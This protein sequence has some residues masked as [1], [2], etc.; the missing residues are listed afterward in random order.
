MLRHK[1]TD[2]RQDNVENDDLLRKIPGKKHESGAERQQNAGLGKDHEQKQAGCILEPRTKR[3][4]IE[5][6][7]KQRR[8]DVHRPKMY[9]GIPVI[10]MKDPFCRDRDQRKGCQKQEI[11]DNDQVVCPGDRFEDPFI[12]I[13]EI[14]HDEET[15]Q[16]D[17]RKSS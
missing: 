15:D 11:R 1:E 5:K 9:G 17:E 14:R 12:V 2:H 4:K 7:L 16:K 3:G 8:Q 13:P 6:P 10:L